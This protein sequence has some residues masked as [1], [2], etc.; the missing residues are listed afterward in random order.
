MGGRT[1]KAIRM[2]GLLHPWDVVL[3]AGEWE[4]NFDAK[5]L[6]FVCMDRIDSDSA[7]QWL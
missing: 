5:S 4:H 2:V 1:Y 7:L 3:K 6:R